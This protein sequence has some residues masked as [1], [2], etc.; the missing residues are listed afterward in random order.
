MNDKLKILAWG[1]SPYVITGFGTVMREV[2]QNLYRLY[3]DQYDIFL[4][5]INYHGSYYDAGE[6]TGGRG[7]F[8]QVP[9]S[10]TNQHDARLYGHERFIDIIRKIPTDIDM[11]FLCEDPFWVGG[12][13]PT[14]QN[15][16]LF[17]DV[18]KG[19]LAQ[20][21]LG[22]IPVICYFPIDGTPKRP[23]IENIAKYD[24]PITYLPF[25]V[26]ACVDAV[27]ALKE[28]LNMIPHG[29]NPELFFP[30]DERKVRAFKRAFFGDKSL[31][32][33]MVLNCNR[34]QLRKLVPQTLLAFKEFQKKCPNSF[35]YL[36]M[37]PLD[38]G[39][40][41]IECCHTIGLRINDDVFFPPNFTTD[42]GLSIQQLNMMFNAAD[43]LVS[44]ATGGGWELAVTQA[45]ATKTAVLAPANT[46][47][48]DL[49]GD[50]IQRHLRRGLLYKSG[51]CLNQQMIFSGDNEVIRPLPDIEDMARKMNWLYHNPK[52]K[53]KMEE[54][55]YNWTMANLLWANNVAPQFHQ[56][57]TQAKQLKIERLLKIGQHIQVPS[58]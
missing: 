13:M 55:A 45:F 1:A 37:A 14:V 50:Q 4:V 27:P 56:V 31:N 51:S 38:L 26:K 2:L 11:I 40:N 12:V 33:F 43:L 49:C 30:V 10:Q 54:T 16:P 48:V 25:G 22:H 15:N 19:E 5:G 44:T 34:N 21:G 47:H 24:I 42:K 17:I 18:I 57:F 8:T 53:E 6:I 52:E 46:S 20:R 36:N 41:L 7:S 58:L 35:L 32:K 9:A 29:V 23:W 3:P 39:W 28:R